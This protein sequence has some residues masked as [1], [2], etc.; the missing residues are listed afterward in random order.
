VIGLSEVDDPGP[1][2]VALRGEAG[3]PLSYV[4]LLWQIGVELLNYES[5][6]LCLGL[7]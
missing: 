4:L 2:V 6:F 5:P 7:K 1:F 3:I